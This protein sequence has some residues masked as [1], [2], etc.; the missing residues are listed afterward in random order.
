MDCDEQEDEIP[1]WRNDSTLPEAGPV[2]GEQLSLQQKKVLAGVLA[3]F[4]AVFSNIPGRTQLAEHR[5]ECGPAKPTWLPP[6]M[7][8]IP[9][10]YR[11][12]M[13]QEL[14]E[15]IIEPVVF[16]HGDCEKEGWGPANMHRLPAGFEQHIAGKCIPG[17]QD[18]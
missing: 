16:T 3:E 2:F 4:A 1:V 9:H 17:A 14:Q 18:Q 10:A 6:Y 15:G 13:Q 8:C 12:A 11:E 7:Y 5:I